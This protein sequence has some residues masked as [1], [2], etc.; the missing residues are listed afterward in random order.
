M[1][2]LARKIRHNWVGKMIHWE[3]CNKVKFH[4]TDKWYI[5]KPESAH[6]NET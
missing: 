4:Q 2:K 1:Q 3:L 5:L 6:K